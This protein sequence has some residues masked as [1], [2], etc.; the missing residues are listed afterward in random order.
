MALKIAEQGLL[1]YAPVSV[2]WENLYKIAEW[3]HWNPLIK[4]VELHE[5]LKKDAIGKITPFVGRPYH[6]NVTHLVPQEVLAIEQAFRFG[7]KLTQIYS[8]IKNVE[9]AIVTV[10]IVCSGRWEKQARLLSRRRLT[11]YLANQMLLMKNLSEKNHLNG[12]KKAEAQALRNQ[13]NSLHQT[14]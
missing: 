3:P 7:T 10:E 11:D 4:K 14:G 12:V 13:T 8:V 2:I 6:F 5:T 1:I 9:G